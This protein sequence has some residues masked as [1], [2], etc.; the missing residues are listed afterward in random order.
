MSGSWVVM[1]VVDNLQPEGSPQNQSTPFINS[2]PFGTLAPSSLQSMLLVSGSDFVALLMFSTSLLKSKS[3]LT[4]LS[5][6]S[7]V[8]TH[9]GSSGLST[10]CS[11][12]MG[13]KLPSTSLPSYMSHLHVRAS[14]LAPSWLGLKRILKLNGERYLDHITWGC[15]SLLVVV[16]YSRF[17]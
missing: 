16:K 14:A 9:T 6:S 3:S 2:H 10:C 11:E 4:S 13:R 17:L 8:P 5:I 12:N 7:N 15:V 1:V